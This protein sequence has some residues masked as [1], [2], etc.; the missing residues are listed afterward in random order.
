V[1]DGSLCAVI[2]FG[3]LG[4]GDPACDYA[5]AWRMLPAQARPV[6]RA[7]LQPDDAA[8][9]NG[10]AWALSISLQELDYYRTGAPTFR[11]I[12]QRTVEAV[13]DDRDGEWPRP[14]RR[15]G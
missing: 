6:F 5:T 13:L 4:V 12:A 7:A 2:D 9:R 15:P 10:R 14:W 11:A 3:C 8:W 1:R